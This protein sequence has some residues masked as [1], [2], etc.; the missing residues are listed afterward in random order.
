ME[1]IKRTVVA[2]SREEWGGTNRQSI[3]DFY[4]S[5]NMLYDIIM[6]N[7]VLMYL[8]TP[9]EFTTLRVNLKLWT[10]VNNNVAIL[11]YQL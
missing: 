2:R 7:V 11:A 10:L 9:I 1:T 4:G 5:E 8:S 6:M 3:E